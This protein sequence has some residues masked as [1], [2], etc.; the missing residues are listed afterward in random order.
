MKLPNN[1]PNQ[2]LMIRNSFLILA[3]TV[4]SILNATSQINWKEYR[5]DSQNF[6]IQS[7][8]EPE[9]TADTSIFNESI[10]ITHN[11]EVDVTDTLHENLYYSATAETYPSNFIHSDSLFSLVEG[12]INS[13]QS[14]LFEDDAFSNLSTAVIEKQGYPGKSFKWK[15]NSNNV[16]FEYQIYLVNSTLYMLSVVADVDKNHNIFIDH[17]FDSFRLINI[18]EGNFALPKFT[19]ERKL[20]VDFPGQPESENKLVDSEYGKLALYT[21]AYEPKTTD[22]NMVY[23]AME[24]KY[25]EN[26][27]NQDDNYALNTFYSKAIEGSLSSLNGELISINDIHYNGKLG[28][29]YKCYYLD[30]Q[31]IVIYR[32]FY[33]DDG[34]YAL[35]VITKSQNDNNEAM[36]SFFK[37]FKIID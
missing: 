25:P 31:F 33:I 30:G 21:Q 32:I 9:Y 37:S 20:T 29:E 36:N 22:D 2:H 11:W 14:F 15:R 12:F 28:K 35:G 23:I 27:I 16:F 1:Q 10:L 3:F 5:Y 26:A 18:P 19:N 7:Y 13:S 6:K 8:Q 17:Y 4:L 34:L 24:T